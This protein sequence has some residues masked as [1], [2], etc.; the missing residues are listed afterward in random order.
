MQ[1][2]TRAVLPL[3]NGVL[4]PLPDDLARNLLDRVL[5]FIGEISELTLYCFFFFTIHVFK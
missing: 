3:A 1:I 4:I 2:S 5:T